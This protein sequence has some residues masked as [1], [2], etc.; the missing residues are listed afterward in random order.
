MPQRRGKRR[1]RERPRSRSR[2]SRG[3]LQVITTLLLS[4]H[5]SASGWVE[6]NCAHGPTGRTTGYIDLLFAFGLAR[7]GETA[8]AHELMARAKGM[9]AGR[10]D[11]HAWLYNAFEYRIKQSLDGKS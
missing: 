11:A 5:D 8:A 10:S 7:I 4:L 1:S 6:R 2:R 9:M 3:R